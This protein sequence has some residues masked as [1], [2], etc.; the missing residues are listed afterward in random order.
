M[1][2]FAPF[3]F[4]E[5]A[6]RLTRAGQAAPLTRKAAQLLRC[7]LDRAGEVVTHE[8]LLQQI[9][10]ST[11]VQPENV[12]TLVHEL[13][14]ALHDSAQA[15]RFIRSE[16][17][18][19]YTFIA[20]ATDAMVPFLSDTEGVPRPDFV[21]RD[22][23]LAAI[24]GHLV[25]AVEQGESQ[26]VIV[27]GDRGLGKTTLC[28]AVAVN[29]AHRHGF[30]ISYGQGLELWGAVDDGAVL[31]DALDLLARQYPRIVPQALAKRAP[32]WNARLA[33]AADGP[34]A[35]SSISVA[36]EPFTIERFVR[37]LGALLDELAATEPL[38]LI[39]E[40]LQWAD[41]ATIEC[42]RVIGRRHARAR[43]VVVATFCASESSPG[44]EVLARVVRD[45]QGAPWCTVLSLKPWSD[46]DLFHWLERKYGEP[47]AR[48]VSLP[49]HRAGGGHPL[50][51]AMAMDS[52][53]RLG[54]LHATSHGWRIALPGDGI[55]SVLA[56]SLTAAY[57]SQIDRLS[58]AERDLLEA[59]AKIG[60]PF[61]AAQ[62]ANE[63]AS[64]TAPVIERRLE[65]L[66]RRQVLLDYKAGSPRGR[67]SSGVPLPPADRAPASCSTTRLCRVNSKPPPSP[68][69]AAP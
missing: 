19:G 28:E 56:T 40:D 9:W 12:K 49:L 8:E 38:L 7:L 27:Q 59:A 53:V 21:G 3:R 33:S 26:L 43:L 52:L 35:E 11:H 25:K 6:G 37:E 17:G 18:R 1:K 4:D 65:T 34:K 66:V 42:L 41:A 68:A 24:D 15:S 39:L 55:E 47:V 13:R 50:V 63:L 31:L 51:A 16:P 64:E 61:T 44:S 36:A 14:S 62:V 5:R 57:Q 54:A 30:R 46:V 10:G 69:T 22:E 29:A 32:M 58:Q 67:D 48:V 23:L 2:Y 45:V 60:H 20:R